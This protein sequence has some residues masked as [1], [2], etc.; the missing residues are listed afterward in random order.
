MTD[1]SLIENSSRTPA[2]FKTALI[3]VFIGAAYYLGAEFGIALS[4]PPDSIAVFWPP[5]AVMVSALVLTER[6]RW[7][8][9]FMAMVPAF[10]IPTLLEGNSIARG[11]IFFAANCTE[12]LIAATALH[13]LL[14]G[15]LEFDQ[16]QRMIYFLCWAVLFAPAVSATISLSRAFIEP[17]ADLGLAWRTWFLGDALAQLVLVPVIFLWVSAGTAWIKRVSRARFLEAIALVIGLLATSYLAFGSSFLGALNNHALLY[18]PLPVLIWATIRFGPIGISTSIFALTLF[19]IISVAAGLGPFSTGSTAENVF[20]LQLFLFAA[21]TPLLMLSSLLD[22][23]RI[24]E[25]ALHESD[26]RFRDII[27]RTVDVIWQID[28]NGVFTFMS[29][30]IKSVS[31]FEPRELVGR[32]L[33]SLVNVFITEESARLAEES[34]KNR[35]AGEF[36]NEVIKTDFTFLRKD[37]SEFVGETRSAPLLDSQGKITVIQGITRDITDQKVVYDE[38]KDSQQLFSSFFS[39]SNDPCS[40]TEPRQGKIIDVNPQWVATF[41]WSR[42]EAIGKDRSELNMIPDELRD[43]FDDML[44]SLRKLKRLQNRRIKLLTRNGEERTFLMESMRVDA[45]GEPRIFTSL[46]DITVSEKIEQELLKIAKLESI[47]VFAGGIAHDLN[48]L[49]TGIMGNLSLARMTENRKERDLLL[50]E[51]ERA[52]E[53]LKG[54][55]QQLL[56]FAKGGEPVRTSTNLQDLL[57]TAVSF[58]L[59]GSNIASEIDIED[60]LWQAYID[61]A[62]IEQVISNLIINAKQ[63]MPN[64]GTLSISAKNFTTDSTTILPLRPGPYVKVSITD[65]GI[66]IPEDVVSKIF[67]PFFSTKQSGSG[68]GL[69]TCYSILQKHGGHITVSSEPNKGSTFDFYLPATLEK[70]EIS[71]ALNE[72]ELKH[73]KGKILVMDDADD[74]RTMSA[75]MLGALGYEVVTC[76]DG[77]AAIASYIAALESDQAFQAVI[78]DLTI[79]GGKGGKE[80]I[81]QLKVT[82]PDVVAIVS[83]GYSDDPV[84]AH[85]KD[86]G[87]KASIPKPYRMQELSEILS[88]LLE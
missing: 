59:R 49:L 23:R 68:L 4:V 66:G 78:L 84:L 24:A 41:G 2:R 18:A 55:T 64:A 62:Q 7:W 5:N 38:L 26:Q 40:I 30:S 79:P 36:G 44:R 39:M 1:S 35:I 60:G 37:G 42:E 71:S 12:I 33:S 73:G 53:R 32:S 63:A 45:A 48:N 87:F 75:A 85:Y 86:Y 61:P 11:I 29:S 14:K 31:G 56:T 25:D 21:I 27:D 65:Q 72:K 54:L 43:S 8:I 34:I 69:A 80:T 10:F 47:G 28:Q 58:A 3:A 77:D 22:A 13:R 83:S 19:S 16:F 50:D 57:G 88:E 46:N 51:T 74:I 76:A 20:A 52:T 15:N 9:W 17:T 6:R 81:S 67:D 70:A 82:N